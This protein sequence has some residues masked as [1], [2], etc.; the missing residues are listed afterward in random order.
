MTDYL[1]VVLAAFGMTTVHK[2]SNATEPIMRKY[3]PILCWTDGKR[4]T[5]I[6]VILPTH[7]SEEK[8]E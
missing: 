4:I 7:S 3:I 5:A 8:K 2:I 6:A 1:N